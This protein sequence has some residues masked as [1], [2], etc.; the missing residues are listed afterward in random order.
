MKRISRRQFGLLASLGLCL[1]GVADAHGPSRQKVVETIMI[2][3]APEAVWAKVKHF[4][5]LQ[6]WH[7]AVESSVTTDGNNVGSERTL[8]LKGGG[9]VLEVLEKYS[10]ESRSYS[11]R[12][13]DPGPL[14][15]G[16]YTSTLTVKPGSSA[17][18]SEVEWRGAFYR[19]Y[20]NND[21]PPEKNDEAAVAAVTG[22]YKTGLGNLKQLLE[23]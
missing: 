3:A 18:A 5:N 2:N 15:V 16:N 10:D 6:G 23:K 8:N 13:K 14:P 19:G 9:I 20:P 4:N 21:P 11:Y 12:M 17:D 7:P 22:I 1:L